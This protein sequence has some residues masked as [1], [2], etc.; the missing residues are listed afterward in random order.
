LR[1]IYLGDSY[2]IV[3]RFWAE[4]LRSISPLYAH[5]RFI[6]V[7]IR[8]QYTAV[9]TIP[10][11]DLVKPPECP[12]GLLLDPHTG[13][14]LSSKSTAEASAS[15]APLAFIAWVNNR[16]RPEYIICFDQSYY[17]RHE[18]NRKGQLEKKRELLREMGIDSFYYY[19]H[20]PFLFMAGDASALGAVKERLVSLGVPQERLTSDAVG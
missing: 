9:T 4:S 20:A 6:P 18:L 2:D 15:H 19:S 12:I 8:A 14:P 11:L 7:D 13:I 5:P 16:L 1:D 10:I 17:R 3:K